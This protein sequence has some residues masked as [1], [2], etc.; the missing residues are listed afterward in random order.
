MK[1]TIRCAT[2]VVA[3]ALVAAT[4]TPPYDYFVSLYQEPVKTLPD[5]Q[6]IDRVIVYLGN[7]AFTGAA[8]AGQQFNVYMKVNNAA[9]Q[10]VCTAGDAYQSPIPTGKTWGAYAFQ[11]IYAKPIARVL[12]GKAKVEPVAL[13]TQYTITAMVSPE[14]P[15]GDRNISNESATKSF[16]FVRGGTPSCV[17]FPRP[18]F[19]Q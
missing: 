2:V 13:T 7:N 12:G 10:Q 6:K 18:T 5:G 15:D 16:T 8:P 14:H 19:H 3:A 11:V 1:L 9:G 4:S 17:S